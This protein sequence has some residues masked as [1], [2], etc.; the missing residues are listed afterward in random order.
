MTFTERSLPEVSVG[1]DY[2]VDTGAIDG[3]DEILRIGFEANKVAGKFSWQAELL[4]TKVIRDD[5]EDVHFTGDYLYASWFL[6]NDSRNYSSATGAFLDVKPN[7]PVWQG[8]WGAWELGLRASSVD[9]NDKDIVGGRQRDLTLG[10]N[11]Y[12][13]DQFR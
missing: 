8:G 9:L 2:F 7:S 10:L 6:S 1:D 13:N 5:A 3:A 11:W 4:A 12:L